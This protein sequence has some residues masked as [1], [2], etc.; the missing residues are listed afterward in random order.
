MVEIKSV[1]LAPFTMLTSSVQAILALI[2][3]IITL[4]VA[5]IFGAVIPQLGGFIIALGVAA[6]IV[7]PIS[8][9]F[10][11]IVISF[12]S[13]LLY[14]TLVPRLGGV[15]LELEGSDVTSIPVV[16]FALILSAISA[17]W[18][19]IVGLFL[20][21]ASAPLFAILGSS[22]EILS[23]IINNVTT[24]TNATAAAIPNASAFAGAGVFFA[25]LLIIGLPII[26]F[27]VGFIGNAL[28]AI[29][30]NLIAVRV[31]KLKLEFEN[32]AGTLH[33]LRSIPVVP[34]ALS[35]AIVQLVFGVITGI[36]NLINWSA[37]G[38]PAVGAVSLV[39]TIISNFI[40]TFIV[41]ALIAWIYNFLVPKIG[42]IKV[43][44]T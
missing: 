28:T 26:V 13:A 23:Q 25:L 4:I 9:F 2:L 7:F 27:V 20:A 37:M 19:F 40:I 3:A 33:E 1:E 22:S 6:I 41:V 36:L 30:Y 44:L 42:G 35:L 17:I 24:A 38:D 5:G 32:V 8:S 29:F 31:A 43:D 14:N 11:T 18:A 15:K 39:T 16:P 10:I 21:F 12:F 34:A